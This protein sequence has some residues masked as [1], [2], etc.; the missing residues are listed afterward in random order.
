M[1]YYNSNT[2]LYKIRDFIFEEKAFA[3]KVFF[4]VLAQEKQVKEKTSAINKKVD[5]YVDFERNRSPKVVH[6]D[7]DEESEI[8]SD[9]I[10][11]DL[12]DKEQTKTE[13][14]KT[15]T[16]EVTI[17]SPKSFQFD[18]KRTTNQTKGSNEFKIKPNENQNPR[19][20]K[21]DRSGNKFNSNNKF[22]QQLQC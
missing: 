1:F 19:P 16:K 7:D 20:T 12:A 11:K 14:K 22:R 13:E 10:R 4:G 3:L 9:N 5:K 6:F 18:W 8:M 2:F 15:E 17:E 21:V